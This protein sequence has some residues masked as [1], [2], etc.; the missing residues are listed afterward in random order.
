MSALLTKETPVLSAFLSYRK[1]HCQNEISEQGENM[2]PAVA[3]NSATVAGDFDHGPFATFPITPPLSG[4]AGGKCPASFTAMRRC[5]K[6]SR[7]R[8]NMLGAT[9]RVLSTAGRLRSHCCLA[10]PWP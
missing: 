2:I 8:D 3:T 6:D 5:E 9:R 7:R 4:E 1:G 10:E